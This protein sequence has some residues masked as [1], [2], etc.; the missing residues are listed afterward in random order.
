MTNSTSHYTKKNSEC[1]LKKKLVPKAGAMWPQWFLSS[2]LEF[3]EL[4]AE[5]CQR[6]KLVDSTT[7][8]FNCTFLATINKCHVIQNTIKVKVDH[9]MSCRHMVMDIRSHALTAS[10]SGKKHRYSFYRRVGRPKD[11][12]GCVWRR[13]NPYVPPGLDQRTLRLYQVPV[14]STLSRS[15]SIKCHFVFPLQFR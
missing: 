5:T 7:S 10:P 11:E 6:D 14:S 2:A 9:S 13:E 8:Y 3:D 1:I 15:L 4:G 12:S